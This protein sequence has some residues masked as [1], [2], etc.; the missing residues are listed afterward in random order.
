ML[1]FYGGTSP[2]SMR[3]TGLF[4]QEVRSDLWSSI[5][6]QGWGKNF[7]YPQKPDQKK[8]EGL[9]E[10]TGRFRGASP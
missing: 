7:R 9:P 5:S 10:K 8:T 3:G 1:H 2:I 6:P 4:F